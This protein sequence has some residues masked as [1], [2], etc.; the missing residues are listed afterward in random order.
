MLIQVGIP[1]PLRH[2]AAALYMEAFRQK[3]TPILGN[4]MQGHTLLAK[5]LMLE[6]GIAA[7]V[8]NRLVGLA[9]LHAGQHQFA[10]IRPFDLIQ[11]FGWWS[12]VNRIALGILLERSAGQEELVLDGIAVDREWRGIGVGTALLEAVVAYARHHHYRTVRLEVVDSNPA[13]KRLYQRLGFMTMH[14]RR[15]GWMTRRL[16]FSAVTT[17]VKLV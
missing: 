3:L 4:E 14:T 10:T 5:G 12:G 16:G 1:E 9:G 15:T 2:D 13:A 7:L 8:N 11:T 17:M 6:Y